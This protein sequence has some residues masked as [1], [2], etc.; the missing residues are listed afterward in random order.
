L[1][2][3]RGTKVAAHVRAL[4]L[5][6]EVECHDLSILRISADDMDTAGKIEVFPGTICGVNVRVA[7]DRQGK[8]CAVS[9]RKSPMTGRTAKCRHRS[10]LRFCQWFDLPKQQEQSFCPWL[11]GRAQIVQLGENLRK[12]D[13][14][15]DGALDQ[16]YEIH[17]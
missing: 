6:E 10:C 7:F 12:I 14:T 9:E 2:G 11:A 4:V 15:H 13:S 1:A 5:S 8:A 3:V 17:S 16:R